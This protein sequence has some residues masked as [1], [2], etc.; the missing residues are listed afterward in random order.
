VL[1]P[2]LLAACSPPVKQYELNDQPL[3]CD[4]GNRFA[5]ATARAMGFNV[6]EFSPA[7]PSTPGNLRGW[8]K[9][10]GSASGQQRIAVRISCSPTGTTIDA[11][12]DGAML[13]QV[14]IKRGFHHAFTNIVSMRAADEEMQEQIDAGTAPASQQRRD[15]QIV[16]EPVRGHESKLDF[17]VDLAAGGILP[18]RVRV[19]NHTAR[20]YEIDPAATRLTATDRKRVS[21]LSPAQAGERLAGARG[22]DGGK[23]PADLSAQAIGE[24]LRAKL[25][26]TT[27][28]RPGEK[29]SGYLYFPLAEYHRGRVVVVEKES[30]ESEGFL[31]EF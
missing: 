22:A 20:T 10:Q 14:D 26:S 12:E 1:L 4:E 3:S 13:A 23:A 5:Y 7:T 18:L 21:P 8:R 28:V 15:L 27:T 16:I 2:L 30:G 9:W 25:F 17:D 24:R 29:A 11:N 6:L 19:N 31:V